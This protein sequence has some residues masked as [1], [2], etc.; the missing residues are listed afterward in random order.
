MSTQG[1]PDWLQQ[2]FWQTADLWSSFVA[3]AD[4]AGRDATVRD[5][6]RSL[7]LPELLDSA[8]RIAGGLRAAGVQPGDTLLVQ[9]R[10]SIDA[11]AA[12]L[13]GFSQ[14]IVAV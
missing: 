6:T 7:T 4:G 8:L 5:E 2:G 13:A 9:S 10:N 3:A 1:E 12:L 11:Y 14:G